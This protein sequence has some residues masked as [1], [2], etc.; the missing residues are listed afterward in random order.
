[1]GHFLYLEL[2]TLVSNQINART[3]DGQ[4][5]K[6][7]ANVFANQRHQ[8]TTS[9]TKRIVWDFDCMVITNSIFPFVIINSGLID[10]M[11]IVDSLLK[12]SCKIHCQIY[13]YKTY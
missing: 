2:M 3:I 4:V 13:N 11:F 7:H 12:F 8:M 1:M 9:V 10:S 6:W 5:A